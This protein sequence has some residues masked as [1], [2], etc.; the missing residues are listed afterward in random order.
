MHCGQYINN[1]IHSNKLIL[2]YYDKTMRVMI[3]NLQEIT[4]FCSMS[5]EENNVTSFAFGVEFYSFGIGLRNYS[6]YDLL[7]F[8]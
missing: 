4:C 6:L 3:G 8:N 5:G 7:S 2:L 1:L